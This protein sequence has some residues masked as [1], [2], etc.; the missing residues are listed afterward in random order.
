MHRTDER[1]SSRRGFLKSIMST[2]LSVSVFSSLVGRARADVPD[3]NQIEDIST[4]PTTCKIRVQIRHANPS[5]S[6]YIDT[7][8]V[9]VDGQITQYPLEPQDTNPFTVDLN[10]ENTRENPNVTASAH[11]NLHGWGTWSNPI[12]IPE[13]PAPIIATIA[14]LATSLL[15]FRNAKK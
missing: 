4:C 3:I 14:I 11:C 9:D 1:L 13:F 10:L 15:M 7:V 8:K 12:Q 2:A 5:D 6:H